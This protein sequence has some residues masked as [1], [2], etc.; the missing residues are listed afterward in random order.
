MPLMPQDFTQPGRAVN[1]HANCSLTKFKLIKR[2]RSWLPAS[3]NLDSDRPTF[4]HTICPNAVDLSKSLDQDTLKLLNK[5]PNFIPKRRRDIDKA[6]SDNRD[7]GWLES[8]AQVVKYFPKTPDEHMIIKVKKLNIIIK[9]ADKG[10]V[11]VAMSEAQ[12]LEMA[13]HQLSKNVYGPADTKIHDEHKFEIE[14]RLELI[15]QFDKDFYLG[16]LR[17]GPKLGIRAAPL[18]CR[19]RSLYFQ[20]KI[21]KKFR[22]S[23]IGPIPVGRPILDSFKTEYSN[24]DKVYMYAIQPLIDLAH[25]VAQGTLEVIIKLRTFFNYNALKFSDENPPIFVSFDVVDLYTNIPVLSALN[26]ARDLLIEHNFISVTNTII[27]LTEIMKRIFAYNTFLFGEKHLVQTNGCPMGAS[28]SGH[29]A[30]IYLFHLFKNTLH[31]Y[32]QNTHFYVRYLDDGFAIIDS[33]DSANALIRELSQL[34]PSIE[35]THEISTKEAIFLDIFIKFHNNNFSTATYT[36]ETSNMQLIH[37]HSQHPFTLKKSVVVARLLH[38]ARLSTHFSAFNSAT[39][40]LFR[41]L[42]KQ[43]YPQSLLRTCFVEFT[44]K[45]KNHQWPFLSRPKNAH[46]LDAIDEYAESMKIQDVKDLYIPKKCLAKRKPINAYCKY[47]CNRAIKPYG[48]IIHAREDD[49]T[50]IKKAKSYAPSLK[51]LLCKSNHAPSTG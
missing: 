30:N 29:L 31:K 28:C 33:V 9:K 2:D 32:A 14:S 42:R 34:H 25:T 12:Y 39:F 16:K 27:Q 20:P 7:L 13:N 3:L 26:L 18:P 6:L 8:A 48:R 51:K 43:Q 1:A 17:K 10:S 49:K 5:G 19:V 11:F 21:H 22:D 41:A 46:L 36:K 47:I 35:L 24:I 40:S 45:I 4:H 44:E 23:D 38:Y 50:A 37:F 15:K